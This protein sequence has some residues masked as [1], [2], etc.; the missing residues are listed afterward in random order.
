MDL[1]IE[2]ASQQAVKDYALKIIGKGVNLVILSVGALLDKAFFKELMEKAN[3][4]GARIYIPSGA[5]GAI[6][7]VKAASIMNVDEI[8]LITRK[9]P[10]AFKGSPGAS[11]IDLNNL[12]KPQVLFEGN[13]E[14][15]VKLFPA[16]VNIAATLSLASGG[17]V[18]VRVVADPTIDLNIH[19]III[20]GDFGEAKIILRNT[21]SP[22]NPRTSLLAILST[23]RLIKEMINPARIGT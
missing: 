17:D 1:V 11:N 7:L 14:D 15:V 23:I 22:A 19:E 9:P 8:L 3:V 12:E 4:S 10:K 20:K 18:K 5:I 16:N 2:A 13:A 6:D 21:P